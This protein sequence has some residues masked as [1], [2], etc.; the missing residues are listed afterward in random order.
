MTDVAF[1]ADASAEIGI[2][3][4][5]RCLTLA[6]ALAARGATCHFLCRAPSIDLVVMIVRRGHRVHALSRNPSAADTKWMQSQSADAAWLGCDWRDDA[7]ESAAVL[8]SLQPDGLVVDHY[9]LDARWELALRETCGRLMVIDD[10]ADRS[11][12]ADLLLD[13]NLS[14]KCRDYSPYLLNGSALLVGT[15]YALLRAEFA[16]WRARSLQR[17]KSPTLEHILV[18]MGGTDAGN[19]TGKILDALAQID[20]PSTAQVTAVLGALAPARE[21]V[22]R[23][24]ASLPYA[25]DVRVGVANMAEL[26]A[27]ADLAIGAAG[28]SSWERCCLGLPSLVVVLADNQRENA[29]SLAHRGAAVMLAGG[30]R[31]WA[32]ALAATFTQLRAPGVLAAMSEAAAGICDGHGTER[33]AERFLSDVAEF[34]AISDQVDHRIGFT[35]PHFNELEHAAMISPG[36]DRI[37]L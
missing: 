36:S 5:A 33:V 3:H 37:V 2:G 17:R 14:R 25:C 4:V 13:Q 12:D 1:R 31:H 26:M 15:D 16:Q 29:V 28:T 21:H 32:R 23:Q 30:E 6:D 27:S 11:H 35:W 22:Q 10:L 20:L 18:S 24:A 34:T 8:R 19:V 9:A 7:A